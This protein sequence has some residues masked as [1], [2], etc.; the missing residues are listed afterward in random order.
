MKKIALLLSLFALCLGGCAHSIRETLACPRLSLPDSIRAEGLGRYYNKTIDVEWLDAEIPKDSVESYLASTIPSHLSHAGTDSTRG[1][2]I[3]ET[4]QKAI[5][6]WHDYKSQIKGDYKVANYR[7]YWFS[8]GS[9]V[10][11]VLLR[12]CII[13]GDIHYPE[14]ASKG[15]AIIP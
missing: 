15:G 8:V 11:I 12:D 4:L 5:Q 10:G 2:I 7:K 14:V 6:K 13:I 1:K 9:A 3:A